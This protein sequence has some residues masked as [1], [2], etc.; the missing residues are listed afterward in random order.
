MY[1]ICGVF[2]ICVSGIPALLFY[3]GPKRPIASNDL[4][5]MALSGAAAYGF[6]LLF[7]S[8]RK[9]ERPERSSKDFVG[10]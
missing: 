9:E 8:G 1:V 10:S 7:K 6:L 4:M 2:A 3:T 5:G